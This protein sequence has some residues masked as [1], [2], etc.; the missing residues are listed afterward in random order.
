MNQG[1]SANDLT[2]RRRLDWRVVRKMSFGNYMF[3]AHRTAHSARCGTDPISNEKDARFAMHYRAR[4][5][6]RTL[7]GPGVYSPYT[8]IHVDTSH[9]FYPFQEPSAWIVEDGT[10]R[11][12]YSPHFARHTPMCNGTIWRPDGGTSARL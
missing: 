6:I 5:G 1:L 4:C 10:S 2:S 3:S 12:P 7:I 11:V 8:I 9:P